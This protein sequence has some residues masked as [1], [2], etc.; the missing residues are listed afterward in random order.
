MIYLKI[1]FHWHGHRLKPRVLSLFYFHILFV[2]ME[3]TPNPWLGTMW[4]RIK[5]TSV[6]FWSKF[7]HLFV[8]EVIH[9]VVGTISGKQL[10]P[11]ENLDK[12]EKKQN[13]F[14]FI[15]HSPVIAA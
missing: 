5:T 4:H 14:Y 8:M 3:W 11:K 12:Q 10:S 7:L 6:L 9:L 13:K 2:E 15:Y 1:Y